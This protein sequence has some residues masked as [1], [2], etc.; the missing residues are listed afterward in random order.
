MTAGNAAL[1]SP[2]EGYSV[3]ELVDI[4]FQGLGTLQVGAVKMDIVSE[5]AEGRHHFLIRQI[6]G[7]LHIPEDI[8][9]RYSAA[10]VELHGAATT[11][12]RRLD[13]LSRCPGSQRTRR[14]A[15]STNVIRRG[16]KSI[17]IPPSAPLQV[18]ECCSTGRSTSA[19]V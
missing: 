18:G 4:E 13:S 6:F 1:V 8:R 2:Y 7:E 12:C 3:E 19:G 14:G 17:S 11:Q 16:Q 15:G 10:N 9:E 5:I